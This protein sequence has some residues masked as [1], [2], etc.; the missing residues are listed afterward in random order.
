M[1]S[2]DPSRKILLSQRVSG[3]WDVDIVDASGRVHY[4][5]EEDAGEDAYTQT[6]L[7]LLEAA[8]ANA[9]MHAAQ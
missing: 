7:A 3:R 6:L 2:P 8:R 5:L 1:P 9:R 4:V